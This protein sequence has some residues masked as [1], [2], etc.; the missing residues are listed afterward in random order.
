MQCHVT[1]SAW[2]SQNPSFQTVKWSLP[3]DYLYMIF[4]EQFLKIIVPACLLRVRVF[5]VSIVVVG[6]GSRFSGDL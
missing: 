2:R 5:R 1:L 4:L 3:R 6:V